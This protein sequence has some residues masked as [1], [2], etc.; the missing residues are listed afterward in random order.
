V[1]G[2]GIEAAAVLGRLRSALHAI[3]EVVDDPG[4]VLSHLDRFASEIRDA[5]GTTVFFAVYERAEHRLRYSC[6]A[7]PPPVVRREGRIERLD[8]ARGVPLGL[9]LGTGP[10]RCASTTLA[11]EDLVVVYTDGLVE[12]RGETID[13]GIERLT[14]ALRALGTQPIEEVADGL[15]ALLDPSGRTDDTAVVCARVPSPDAPHRTYRIPAD[16]AQLAVLRR[17]LRTWLAERGV[18]ASAREEIMVAVTEAVSNA[19]EHGYGGDDT[20]TVVVETCVSDTDVAVTVRDRGRWLGQLRRPERGRGLH[21]MRDLMGELDVTPSDQGT[22]VR[23][24][25]ALD[26]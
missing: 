14:D 17:A 5:A 19:I 24:R 23:M 26:A 15:L 3:A 8:G 4:D 1:V 2:S 10:L 20:R 11:P 18:E 22:I 21:L 7:P 25:R 9:G 6:A 13:V 12:R 16:P